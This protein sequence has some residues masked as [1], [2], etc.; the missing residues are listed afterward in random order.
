MP[1]NIAWFWQ[2]PIGGEPGLMMIVDIHPGPDHPEVPFVTEALA[3][4]LIDVEKQLPEDIQLS[5][6]RIY[7]R[8]ILG[9]WIEISMD[10][11]NRKFEKKTPKVSTPALQELW[12]SRADSEGGLL[13]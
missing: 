10:A 3:D 13:Q 12:F 1:A 5:Q 4:V 8:D 7:V 11:F 9:A 6:L 2:P